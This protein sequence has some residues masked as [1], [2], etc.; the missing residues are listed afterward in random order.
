[1]PRLVDSHNR[2]EWVSHFPGW[3]EASGAGGVCSEL[4]GD[5]VL[6]EGTGVGKGEGK[7]GKA[8]RDLSPCSC[9]SLTW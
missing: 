9:V 5:G 4:A 8:W 1:M 3:P 7:P 6:A 2:Q